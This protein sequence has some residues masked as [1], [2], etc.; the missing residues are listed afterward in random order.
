VYHSADSIQKVKAHQDLPGDFLHYVYRETF[1]VV[2]FEDLPKIYA[3]N[4]EYHA[5]M[6]AIWTFV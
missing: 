4:L 2:F 6:V 5:E 1:A 3:Q